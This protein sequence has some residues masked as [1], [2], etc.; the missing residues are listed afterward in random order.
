MR[1]FC[2]RCRHYWVLRYLVLTFFFTYR[3]FCWLLLLYECC[4]LSA[5]L[6]A[7][8][9]VLTILLIMTSSFCAFL[10]QP[11]THPPNLYRGLVVHM[12]SVRL[13]QRFPQLLFLGSL[14]PLRGLSWWWR[15][16]RCWWWT[17][18]SAYNLVNVWIFFL[19]THVRSVLRVGQWVTGKVGRTMAV[20]L[21]IEVAFLL[22]CFFSLQ[23]LSY[24]YFSLF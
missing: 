5:Q 16:C 7:C 23:L 12:W 13:V 17:C 1:N 22:K 9:T 20:V 6:S 8:P 2:F 19:F 18:I 4:H 24:C 11:P 15:C 21:V 10:N 3:G 14:L